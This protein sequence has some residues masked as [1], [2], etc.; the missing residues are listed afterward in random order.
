MGGIDY[1]N[2][3]DDP[4]DDQGHGT[5]CAGIVAA[6]DNGIGVIGAAPEA[7]LYGVKIL[8]SEGQGSYSDI[9]AG[10][11]WSVN[12]DMQVISMSIS[13]DSYSQALQDACDAANNS[14]VVLVAAAG[15]N[16]NPWMPPGGWDNVGYP[17]KYESVIAVAATDSM[18]ERPYWSSTGATVELA[19][20]GVQITMER[21]RLMETGYGQITRLG[22][23]C[24]QRLMIWV[25]REEITYSALA[26]SMPVR[27]LRHRAMTQSGR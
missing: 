14:G 25:I 2:D 12:N 18:D 8:N 1:V 11:E 4:M 7:S 26:W 16:G 23:F 6:V 3:D 13:G 20:P 9:I 15:N 24:K 17:A 19:A 10:I 27:Q 21:T 22:L 5:H